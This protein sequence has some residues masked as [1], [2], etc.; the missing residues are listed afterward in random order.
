MCSTHTNTSTD[1]INIFCKYQVQS[2]S[3]IEF[4]LM[5]KRRNIVDHEKRR[6]LPKLNPIC[7]LLLHNHLLFARY[8]NVNTYFIALNH[9]NIFYT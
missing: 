6:R 9:P 2:S 1:N 5:N 3:N 8:S 7:P 4:L